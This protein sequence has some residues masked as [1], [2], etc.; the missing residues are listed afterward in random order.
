[1]LELEKDQYT[2]D[3]VMELFKPFGEQIE[4]LKAEV[5]KG[6]E[7]IERIAELE[8]ANLANSIKLEVTKA[9]LN[10][11]EVFDLV[12]ADTLEVAQGKIAKLVEIS[13]K[14]KIDNSFKPQD[15]TGKTD[16]YSIFE[17]NNDVGGMLKSKLSK[18]FE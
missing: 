6:N 7:A 1:M 3:E 17:K 5:T 15:K 16:D 8:S 12:N 14:Q 10:I 2:K 9:G 4:G 13:K 11:D 18:L